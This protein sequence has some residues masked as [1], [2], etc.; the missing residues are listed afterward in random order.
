MFDYCFK[1]CRYFFCC[2]KN[3]WQYSKSSLWWHKNIV[4]FDFS[5][6]K[7]K[8]FLTQSQYSC[9]KENVGRQQM[10]FF[11]ANK[12][13]LMVLKPGTAFL[14]PR[15]SFRHPYR[16]IMTIMAKMAIWPFGHFDDY[17]HLGHFCYNDHY[18]PIWVSKWASGLQDRSPGLQN[19]P[20]Y[21]IQWKK[22][23]M[24]TDLI[25]LCIFFGFP[26]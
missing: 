2:N 3:N 6:H 25:F 19:H 4:I 16:A 26:L 23:K 14:K 9:T 7:W 5:I 22:C 15:R 11:S 18:R 20:K 13:F 21:F 12:I 10:S 8:V 1:L 24:L 17:S